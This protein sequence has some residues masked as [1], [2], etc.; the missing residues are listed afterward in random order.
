MLRRAEEPKGYCVNCAVAEFLWVFGCRNADPSPD[1][2]RVKPVQDQ[3][4]KI[5]VAR[6]AD[7][8][9][10]EINWEKVIANWD[11]PFKVGRRLVSPVEHPIA[12]PP[13]RPRKPRR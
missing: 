5:M 11:L 13:P 6:N 9:P 1:S 3:F 8:N 7:A 10:A 4:T 2:F 12:P